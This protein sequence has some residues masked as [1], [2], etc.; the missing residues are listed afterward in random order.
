MLLPT[1]MAQLA[2]SASCPVGDTFMGMVEVVDPGTGGL[3][4]PTTPMG[5]AQ[6]QAPPPPPAHYIVCE[7]LQVM[8]GTLSYLPNTTGTCEP[9]MLRKR[10]YRQSSNA[11]WGGF[12][13]HSVITDGADLIGNL[14][15]EEEPDYDAGAVPSSFSLFLVALLLLLLMGGGGRGGR[16]GSRPYTSRFK[17][18]L[19]H[20]FYPPLFF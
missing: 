12:S 16:R 20:Y 10:V 13:R 15:V 17:L 11:T 7:N 19:Y 3:Y 1:L 6:A 4:P 2:C 18:T 5:P 8:N 14:F 9:I